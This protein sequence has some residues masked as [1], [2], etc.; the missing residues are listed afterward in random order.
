LFDTRLASSL[1]IS[2]SI[3]GKTSLELSKILEQILC[4]N[5][6]R[7]NVDRLKDVA[8]CNRQPDQ[9]NTHP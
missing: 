9:N 6:L 8:L 5:Q 7:D 3:F 1:P 2:A 4:G